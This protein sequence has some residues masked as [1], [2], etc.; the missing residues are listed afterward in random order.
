MNG[1]LQACLSD[2]WHCDC[3]WSV[4]VGLHVPGAGDGLVD[5]M[6]FGQGLLVSQVAQALQEEET[7]H[8]CP[9]LH[10]IPDAPGKALAGCR[11]RGGHEGTTALE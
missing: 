8:R 3:R 10:E 9:L 5:G 4:C 11:V 6:Q 7:I 1:L 2:C